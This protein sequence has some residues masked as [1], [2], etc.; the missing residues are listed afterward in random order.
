M[1]N[2]LAALAAF[3][4]ATEASAAFVGWAAFTRIEGG[5]VFLDVFANFSAPGDRVLNVFNS[6]ITAADCSFLQEG[7]VARKGWAP[8]PGQTSE[9]ADSFMTIGMMESGGVA[10]AGST[11]AGDPGFTGTPG[12]WNGTPISAPMP[13]I[14]AN[15]GWY[16]NL[17]TTPQAIAF[18]LGAIDGGTWQNRTAAFGVW[19][20]HFAFDATLLGALPRVSF[21]A[22]VGYK[23]NAI[24]G[25]AVFGTGS[26][27]FALIPAPGAVACLA[28]AGA[29]S[30]RRRVRR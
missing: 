6:N 26:T 23:E 3:T 15:A 25:P 18:D 8:A 11:T 20:S 12:A 4:L 14:P 13:T 21:S 22:S 30:A 16:S 28:C 27:S 10:Y 17:P 1:T 7:T 9:D 29:A 19:V 24:P 2:Q 5:T